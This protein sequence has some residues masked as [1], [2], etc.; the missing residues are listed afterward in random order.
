MITVAISTMYSRLEAIQPEQFPYDERV[1]YVISCQ[2]DK[3]YDSTFYEKKIKSLFGSSCYFILLDGYGL[4]KNRNA[5]IKL[6]S[7]IKNCEYIYIAD[8]DI[9][10]DIN[11][12]CIIASKLKNSSF[13]FCVGKISTSNGFFK[14]YAN[15]EYKI[16]RL[17]AAKI[18]SVELMISAYMITKYDIIFDERFGLGSTYPSGE[19]L[20][21]CCD[22]ISNKL[23]GV[24]FPI[25]LSMHSPESSGQNFYSNHQKIVAKGAMF[26]RAFGPLRGLLL[27]LIFSLKKYPKYRRNIS[28]WFFLLYMY[29]GFK[30]IKLEPIPK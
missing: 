5:A 16:T 18:S 7:K 20:I 4:S 19:E 28:F 11:G 25:V 12:I 15:Y 9:Y 17:R 29:K 26:K 23:K 14:N 13:D 22:A 8:D 21:Y 3:I 2:G 1:T 6:A 30:E 24:Y 10:V 27:I